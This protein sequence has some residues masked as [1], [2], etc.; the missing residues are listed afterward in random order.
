MEEKLKL[1]YALYKSGLQKN[2]QEK[3]LIKEVDDIISENS[4][5]YE[6]EI[7]EIRNKR[8]IRAIDATKFLLQKAMEE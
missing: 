1:D 4:V 3:K 6:R 2:K 5:T 8:K 7:P